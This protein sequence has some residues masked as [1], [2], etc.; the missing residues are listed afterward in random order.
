MVQRDVRRN[1]RLLAWFNFLLDFRLYMPVMVIYFELITHSYALAMS[2]LSVTMLSA[3]LL[4]VPTGLFSDMVG[5]K[6][7]IVA[8]A[9]ASLASG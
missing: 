6:R 3:A 5:R 7:T 4:E 8:G 1:I 2:V 9:I